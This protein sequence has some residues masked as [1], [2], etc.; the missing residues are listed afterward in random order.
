MC[1]EPKRAHHA[2]PLPDPVIALA[3]R[4]PPHCA[5]VAASHCGHTSVVNIAECATQK[6]SLTAGAGAA[7]VA[8][9]L[10]CA[11]SADASRA[12]AFRFSSSE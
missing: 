4:L 5:A 10:P 12:A 9:P 1:T 3:S 2:L 7:S 11:A 6:L 8:A